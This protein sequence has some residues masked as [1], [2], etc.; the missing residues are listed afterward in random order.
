MSAPRVRR[1]PRA[2]PRRSGPHVGRQRSRTPRRTT[3]T[4]LAARSGIHRAGRAGIR[5]C[6]HARGKVGSVQHASTGTLQD[7]VDCSD[8]VRGARRNVEPEVA[9]PSIQR[10]S[11]ELDVHVAPSSGI[12]VRAQAR[13]GVG[14]ACLG[15]GTHPLEGRG[16][17]R[18]AWRRR[19]KVVQ[20]HV[21]RH[22]QPCPAL[23]GRVRTGVPPCCMP[24]C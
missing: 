8:G 12:Q 21:R 3:G 23:L 17:S 5:D 6:E 10:R 4:C 15:R 19:A 14:D 7:L 13:G 11:R 22:V 24:E 20:T 18:L 2:R 9:L 1:P 16:T